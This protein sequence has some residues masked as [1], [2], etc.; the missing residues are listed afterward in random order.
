MSISGNNSDNGSHAAHHQQLTSSSH[1]AADGSHH[2]LQREL[3]VPGSEHGHGA[4]H[5]HAPPL[6]P[7]ENGG[8]QLAAAAGHADSHHLQRELDVAA[9]ATSD[10]QHHATG[11]EHASLTD[12][13]GNHAAHQLAS[14]AGHHTPTDNHHQLQRE[15]SEVSAH[16]GEH[17]AGTHDHAPLTDD[18]GA[19][20]GHQLASSSHHAPAP[21]SH[22]Q[23]QREMKVVTH[24]NEHHGGHGHAPEYQHGQLAAYGGGLVEQSSFNGGGFHGGAHFSAAAAP[25]A[26]SSVGPTYCALR[27]EWHPT[28]IYS[29]GSCAYLPISQDGRRTSP[30]WAV[31]HSAPGNVPHLGKCAA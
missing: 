2:Q 3:E 28:P 24:G 15:L 9:H 21:D 1:H 10:H 12:E 22:H 4:A 11:H 20:A 25:G 29:D 27:T 30:E 17:H 7:D 19:H 6:A 13:N 26:G 31:A 8:H 14:S 5:D 23:L 16:G 18:N